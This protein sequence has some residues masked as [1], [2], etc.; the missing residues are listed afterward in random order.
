VSVR[1]ATPADVAAIRAVEAAAFGRDDE[2]DLVE[3]LRADGAVL[4]ELVF[5]DGGGV[6][7]HILFSALRTDP[8]KAVAALAPVA[9]SPQAQGRGAG[10]ALCRAGIETC[11]Q[12]GQDAV[13]VLGEPAYYARFGFSAEAARTV[14]TVYSHLPAFMALALKPDALEP[15][16]KAE[17]PAAFG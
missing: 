1:A 14:R 11:R 12:L 10:S 6:V 8:P 15:L 5:E 13:L 2:A 4:A 7:G 17:Y 3:A 16:L 9:V